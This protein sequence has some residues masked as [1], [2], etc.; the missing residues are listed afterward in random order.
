[1]P[2]QQNISAECTKLSKKT[3]EEPSG[4]GWVGLTLT[5]TLGILHGM[6]TPKFI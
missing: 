3:V 6:A 1:M 2:F 4:V 5:L